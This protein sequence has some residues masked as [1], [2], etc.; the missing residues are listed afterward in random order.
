MAPMNKRRHGA[1]FISD[2]HHPSRTAVLFETMPRRFIT[3]KAAWSQ[4]IE[5]SFEVILN[6]AKRFAF[7]DATI[8][9]TQCVGRVRV[10]HDAR[11][12]GERETAVHD[13]RGF[14]RRLA[15]DVPDIAAY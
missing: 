12:A 11:H 13:L 8:I 15:T 4:L 2:F 7:E 3:C 1:P 9:I 14:K 5:P 6:F 10:Q